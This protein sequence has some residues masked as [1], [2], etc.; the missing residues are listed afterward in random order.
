MKRLAMLLWAAILFSGFLA[1]Q[2]VPQVRFSADCSQA[3][4]VIGNKV[5]NVNLWFFPSLWP[6][7]KN[8]GADLTPFVEYVHFMQ[9]TG[10]S[11]DRDPFKNPQ[12]RSVLDDYNFEPLY[13]ACEITL[14]FRAKPHIKFSIPSKFLA[15]GKAG[16]FGTNVYPPDDYAVYGRFVRDLVHGLVERFGLDE[17]RSWRFGVMTEFENADW[18]KARSG[19]A[20][21]SREAYF[22]LYDF[23]ADALVG[24]L[25]PDV[26]VGAHA[27]SCVEGLW[28]E[29]DLLNHCASGTNYA[30]G[31]TGTPIRFMACS[32]YDNKPGRPNLRGL[33][34]VVEALRQRA[35]EVGLTDLIYGV[36]EGRI[37][38]GVHSGTSSDGL[39]WRVVGRTYQAAFDA[40]LYKQ[41]TDHNIDYFSA[42]SYSSGNAYHGY[43]TVAYYV[44]KNFAEFRAAKSAP[45]EMLETANLPEGVEAGAVVGVEP[46]TLRVMAYNFKDDW[47]YAGK[48]NVTLELTHT[49]FA[50]K[51][52]EVV[53]TLIDDRSNYFVQWE[54]DRAEL[55][56]GDAFGPWSPDD[57]GLD[58]SSTLSDTAVKEI[59]TSRLR[60]NYVKIANSLTPSRSTAEVSADGNLT[61]SVELPRQAVVFYIVRSIN[62]NGETAQ[63]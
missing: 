8:E 61:L 52:V 16:V 35:E 25:G 40:R 4:S 22:K 59:Y 23:T 60:E 48:A 2:E 54:K 63:E 3:A 62:E 18:F 42:W 1:A 39:Q 26:F 49:P 6:A 30:T 53:E 13:R 9:A 45:V 27:M 15:D 55:G 57:P 28:D 56:L 31:E 20:E 12:D 32:F 5:S 36:D 7:D 24:E 29:R 19:S 11:A 47:D 43:P 58:I 33:V 17:V 46:R 38:C 21:E 34:N 41:M 14:S 50:G 37:L 10:S 44:A 51:T